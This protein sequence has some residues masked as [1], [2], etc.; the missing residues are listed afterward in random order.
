MS[1]NEN[2]NSTREAVKYL[3]INITNELENLVFKNKTLSTNN[4]N[5][6]EIND[7]TTTTSHNISNPQ[8]LNNDLFNIIDELKNKI[9]DSKED[10]SRILSLIQTVV[11]HV[12]KLE[13]RVLAL[14]TSGTYKTET[15]LSDFE[16]LNNYINEKLENI[17]KNLETDMTNIHN[18]LNNISGSINR[19]VFNK[20]K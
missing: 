16:K 12:G 14:E 6:I 11:N 19:S 4:P 2:Y 17:K 15:T 18:R 5:I 1:N 8:I 7:L 3:D 9:T 13:E 10:I 20:K